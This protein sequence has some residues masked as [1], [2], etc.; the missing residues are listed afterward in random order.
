MVRT[1]TMYDKYWTLQ[2]NRNVAA[3]SFINC[4]GVQSS[5]ARLVLTLRDSSDM[6][7]RNAGIEVRTGR[8]WSA[9]NA[10]EQAES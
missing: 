4:R 10:V 7:I 2:Q 3:P 6:S 8:R 5:K 9:S 1:S